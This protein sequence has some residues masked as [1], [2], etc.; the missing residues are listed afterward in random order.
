MCFPRK[1]NTRAWNHV[2]QISYTIDSIRN[3]KGCIS[4]TWKEKGKKSA[5]E[6]RIN[7]PYI[8]NTTT[9]A[10]IC[11]NTQES[12]INLKKSNCSNLKINIKSCNFL[13]NYWAKLFEFPKKWLNPKTLVHTHTHTHT[14]AR[15]HTH[16]QTLTHTHIH[17]HACMHK[18]TPAHVH[19]HT[20]ATTQQRVHTHSTHA[21]SQTHK[22]TPQHN[23]HNTTQRALICTST[24]KSYPVSTPS[25]PHSR[26]DWGTW[27]HSPQ[28]SLC[29]SCLGCW[30]STCLWPSLALCQQ[31]Q[32]ENLPSLSHTIHTTTY[33]DTYIQYTLAH[34]IHT[35][36]YDTHYHI[37]YT[38]QHTCMM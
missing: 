37:Q 23:A 14:H 31:T 21:L 4:T 6:F 26:L 28:P 33:N 30:V 25:C 32:Q 36:T 11:G 27:S 3:F 17:K 18:C 7:M 12:E 13:Y 2:N 20:H 9:I 8:F 19:T 5:S 29:L 1:P 34:T 35:S 10:D 38:L 16:T 22:H 24:H 15:T